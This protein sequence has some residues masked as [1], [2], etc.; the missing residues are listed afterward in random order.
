[1]SQWTHV[2]GCIRIDRFPWGSN[3]EKFK[4]DVKEAFGRTCSFEDSEEIWDLCDVPCGSEGSVQYEV[5]RTGDDDSV[6][7][8]LVY[9]WGDLRD[10]TNAQEIYKWI[11]V[12]CENFDIR[13]CAVEVK[14]ED[15]KYFIH[16]KSEDRGIVI[17]EIKTRKER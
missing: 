13:Q 15:K 9:I 2:A 8:G 4:N 1:M 6:A 7:W 11:K 5:V 14:C 16:Y 10:Y 3:I 12:S 17:K